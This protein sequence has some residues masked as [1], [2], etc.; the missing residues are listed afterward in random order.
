MTDAMTAPVRIVAP[1]FS[2]QP[3]GDPAAAACDGEVCVIPD[4]HEQAVINRRIDDDAI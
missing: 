3:L 1:A 4:H 2:L